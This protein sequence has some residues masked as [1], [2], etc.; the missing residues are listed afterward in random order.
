MNR[1]KVGPHHQSG[2]KDA[3]GMR[4][5]GFRLWRHHA[6]L[7]LMSFKSTKLGILNNNCIENACSGKI[8]PRICK[9]VRSLIEIQALLSE[10]SRAEF[11]NRWI[12]RAPMSHEIL[13]V[14]LSSKLHQNFCGFTK[15][16]FY[17][18]LWLWHQNNKY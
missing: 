15:T 12:F 11:F 10:K 4:E 14:S 7:I 6:V 13:V 3:P 2:S 17:P 8:V 16:S 1:K 9:P 5:F 18:F